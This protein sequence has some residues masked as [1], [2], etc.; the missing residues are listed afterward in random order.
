MLVL[1]HDGRS[2]FVQVLDGGNNPPLPELRPHLHVHL[3][4]PFPV[5]G[6]ARDNRFQQCL[7]GGLTLLLD[8]V[9]PIVDAPAEEVSDMLGV[10]GQVGKRLMDPPGINFVRNKKETSNIV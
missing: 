7:D 5:G 1:V 9:L 10:I 6:R 2:F 4:Q 3:H 8:P